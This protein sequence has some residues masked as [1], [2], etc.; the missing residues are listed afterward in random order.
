MSGVK[1]E[2]RGYEV[3]D[4]PWP[5]IR[6]RSARRHEPIADILGS[7]AGRALRHYGDAAASSPAPPK[8]RSATEGYP[9]PSLP[10]VIVV[11]VRYS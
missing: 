4:N 8:R 7:D 11:P 2:S 1:Y 9:Q 6:G 5:T 3:R 10:W